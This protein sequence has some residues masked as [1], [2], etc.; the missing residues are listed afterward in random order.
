MI[1]YK[2]LH[3]RCL[4]RWLP[5]YYAWWFANQMAWMTLD[6]LKSW[7]MSLNVHFKSQMWK[8]L[9]IRDNYA[10]Y[11]L[12]HVGRHDSFGF[13]TLQFKNITDAFLPPNVTSVVQPLDHGIM[14]SSIQQ[15][16]NFGNETSLSL[17]LLLLIKT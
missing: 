10:T 2:S 3:P 8:V 5:T 7:M 17:I 9:L 1:I 14:A 6:V 13:S 12:K 11:L 16:K 15:R 4:E